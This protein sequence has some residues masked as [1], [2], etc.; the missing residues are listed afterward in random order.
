MDEQGEWLSITDAAARL[1]AAGDAVDRS[2]LS[3]YL[4]QHGE[5]LPLRAAGKSNLVEF[6][7]LQQHRQENIRIRSMPAEVRPAPGR[8]VAAPAP[9]RFVGSQADGAARK[10]QADAEMRE[11]DLSLRRKELVPA[12]EVDRAGRSAVALMQSAYEQALESEAS[13][14]SLKYGWDERTL[15]IVLKQLVRKGLEAFN[16]ELLKSIDTMTRS[17]EG[18]AGQ[19]D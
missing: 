11:M 5:A 8:A 12:I 17:E 6:G 9:G 13:S 16:R 14:A 15:R 2:T 19:P 4:K 1:T 10:V 18:T 7:A 3:R